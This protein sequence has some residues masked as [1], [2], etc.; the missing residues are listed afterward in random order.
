MPMYENDVLSTIEE[1]ID[2]LPYVKCDISIQLRDKTL[3][4]SKIKSN[5]IGFSTDNN[6]ENGVSDR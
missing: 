6:S 5:K 2:T 4:L 1:L 3:T